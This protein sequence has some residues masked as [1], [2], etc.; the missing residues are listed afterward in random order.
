MM[1]AFEI[2]LDFKIFNDFYDLFTV[3]LDY[4]LMDDEADRAI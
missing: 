1:S 3:D 4:V 2:T